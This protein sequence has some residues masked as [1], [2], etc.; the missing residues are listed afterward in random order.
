MLELFL[1]KMK[2]ENG[3]LETF[4]KIQPEKTFHY[5][6]EIIIRANWVLEEKYISTNK[7]DE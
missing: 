3:I 2:T 1:M 4:K 7:I 6:E 5:E